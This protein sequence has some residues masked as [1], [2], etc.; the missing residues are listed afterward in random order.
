MTGLEKQTGDKKELKRIDLDVLVRFMNVLSENNS[1][2]ITNLQMST[3]T[4]YE[5]CMRYVRLLEKLGVVKMHAKGKNKHVELT[6]NGSEVC[7]LISV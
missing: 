5:T 1:I 4:N 2:G 3:R 6:D 7:R